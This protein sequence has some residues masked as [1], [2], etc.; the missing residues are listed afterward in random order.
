MAKC[1]LRELRLTILYRIICTYIQIWI[2]SHRFALFFLSCAEICVGI[3]S[4][5]F[6]S[7]SYERR[8]SRKR[9][10]RERQSPV[11]YSEWTY[12]SCSVMKK[13]PQHIRCIGCPRFSPVLGNERSHSFRFN[14]K[15]HAQ[16][17][18]KCKLINQAV[19]SGLC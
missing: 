11:V 19:A 4:N 1:H 8:M 14:Y 9:T 2:H 7:A 16:T 5:V 13:K 12:T 18:K 3:S 10:T 17:H 15:T 6:V